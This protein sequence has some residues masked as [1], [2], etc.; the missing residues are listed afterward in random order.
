MVLDINLDSNDQKDDALIKKKGLISKFNSFWD[1]VPY[2]KTLYPALTKN[3]KHN[4]EDDD[5]GRND[6]LSKSWPFS[7]GLGSQSGSQLSA[8]R[9]ES[10]TQVTNQPSTHSKTI[11]KYIS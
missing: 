3:H 11:K 5:D 8:F 10:Q 7:S 4:D 2:Y 1:I 6:T 9:W